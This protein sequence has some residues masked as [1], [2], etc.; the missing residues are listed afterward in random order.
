MT[1]AKRAAR[2]S[3]RK[4]SKLE[5]EF[6]LSNLMESAMR[7]REAAQDGSIGR[8][9]T[10][11]DWLLVAQVLI[12]CP[13]PFRPTKLRQVTRRTRFHDSFVTIT[14]TAHR[15]GI[16]LPTAS[17]ARMLHWLLNKV[18][19]EAR[20]AQTH[21]LAYSRIV[22]WSSGYSYLQDVGKTICAENYEDLRASFSRISGLGITL[23]MHDENGDRGQ[24]TAF[25][26]SWHLP[27]SVDLR[28]KSSSKDAEIKYSVAVSEPIVRAAM[29][30]F[31]AI[32]RVLWRLTKNRPLKGALMLWA[33]RRAYAAASTSLVSWDLLRAQ[34]GIEHQNPQRIKQDLK[35]AVT[36]LRVM[37]PGCSVRILPAGVE[38]SRQTAPF[39]TKDLRLD[40]R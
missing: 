19:Q 33:F 31:V 2:S 11:D 14:Y 5:K 17:D 18:V 35:E 12:D 16:A 7:I 37:W 28:S 1:S 40:P 34:F 9:R 3:E 27:P 8:S 20:Q 15:P 26:E 25:L 23:E 13:L 22:E 29:E 6:G 32:P 21:G 24:H 38:F 10:A 39:A 30:H 4:P 36:M